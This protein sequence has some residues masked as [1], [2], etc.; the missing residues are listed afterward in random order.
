MK[1]NKP[2]AAHLADAR[3]E[4]EAWITSPPYEKP[5]TANPDSS[6]WPG[7]YRAYEV[8]LA[9]EAYQAGRAE[10]ALLRAAIRRLCN[11]YVVDDYYDGQ[12]R[13]ERLEAAVNQAIDAAIAE[14][15]GGARWR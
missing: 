8:Q 5:V 9:W 7:Q 10:C 6:G 15:E 12:L 1:T 13:E 3:A 4:F 11:I 2:E 14:G